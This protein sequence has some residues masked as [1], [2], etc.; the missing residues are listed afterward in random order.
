MKKCLLILFTGLLTATGYTQEERKP[1]LLNKAVLSGVGLEKVERKDN[2]ER[3]FFQKRLFRGDDLSAYIVS[4]E[5]GT[6][7]FEN[8]PI[9]EFI[10]MLNG[11]AKVLMGAPKE[12]HF[13]ERDFF[14][15]HKGFTGDWHIEAG[16]YVHY[17]L[18]VIATQRADSSKI[19]PD[20]WHL[21]FDK[22]RLSGARIELNDNGL[23]EDQ[24]VKGAELTVL[25]KAE[26]ALEKE[27]K[28]I[29][30]DKLI[31]L[32]SGQIALIDGTGETYTFYSGDFFLLPKGLKGSW[33]SEGHEIIKYLQVEKTSW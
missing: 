17:E 13:F 29:N 7:T 2:P 28:N 32:L 20:K 27:L 33:R 24:L 18:S 26:H 4:S 5:T 19:R 21:L 31:C 16:S 30:D 3:R 6:N 8:F 9:D 12:Q 22:Q 23:Y 11:E 10:Y 14:F 25:L 15:A 1:I